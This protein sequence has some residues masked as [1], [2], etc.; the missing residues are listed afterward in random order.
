MSKLNFFSNFDLKSSTGGW[1]GINF[2]LFNELSAKN[3]VC[4]C[5]P[6]NPPALSLETLVSRIQKAFHIPRKYFFYSE[7]R[8][9]RI[10][11]Q[12]QS[13]SAKG[14]Y[15]FFFGATPWVLCETKRNYFTYLDIIFPRYIDV[16]LS[17]EKFSKRDIE[18]IS[19]LEKQF[20][21]NAGHVFWGSNWAKKEAERIYKCKFTQSTVISTGGHIPLPTNSE[22]SFPQKQKLLF[23]SLNFQKK[24]GYTVYSAFQKLKQNWPNIELSI[25]GEKPPYEILNDASV[26]YVGKLDKNKE[27]DVSKLIGEIK[28]SFFLVHPTTMDTMGAVIVEAGYYGLPTVAPN[29]FG[30]PDIIEHKK[31]GVLIDV[32]IDVDQ[33]VYYL[34]YYLRNELVY[35]KLRKSTK[36]FMLQER[37]WPAIAEKVIDNIIQCE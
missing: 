15:D 11:E 5:G 26:E 34:D 33:I 36:H 1:N 23:I 30:I 3:D 14:N 27:Y 16:F 2:N 21:Q 37:S 29:N 7:N 32:P 8:L 24:G 9:K 18:R 10:N 19:N 31:T 28:S 12:Y 22:S 20:L 4:Y 13:S 35:H 25:I 6:I 17:D